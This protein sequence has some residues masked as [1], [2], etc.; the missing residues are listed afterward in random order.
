M[1]HGLV[2][3]VS[4]FLLKNS[5][6]EEENVPAIK[7]GLEY[8]LMSLIVI[9]FLTTI[10]VVFSQ[11]LQVIG[12]LLGFFLIRN[13]LGGYHTS[14]ES[15]CLSL[16]LL[17]LTGNLVL[18]NL[19]ASFRPE[20]LYLLMGLVLILALVVKP[21][22]HPNRRF[23]PGEAKAFRKKFILSIV[24]ITIAAVV[25][26]IFFQDLGRIFATSLFMGVIT[27]IIAV[28]WVIEKKKRL[29]EKNENNN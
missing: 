11:S 12:L 24:F 21:V 7:Y 27:A 22:D 18:I 17:V 19:I 26:M 23:A 16:S 25:A 3:K 4:F 29:G 6:I 5:V 8:L 13:S 15:T 14:K 20:L 10:S 2:N 1:I 9:I 28:I